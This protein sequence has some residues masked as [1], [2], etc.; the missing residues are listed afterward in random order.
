MFKSLIG[1][2]QF[3]KKILVLMLPIMIQNGITN[4]VNLLDN[5]MV[6]SLGTN[7]MTGVAISN[8]LIFVF[9]LCIFGAVSGASIFGAQF[10]GKG[11]DDGLRHTLRYK[12]IFCVFLTVA[13]I[14]VFFNFGNSLIG[15]YLKGEGTVTDIL[16]TSKY[17]QGYLNIILIGLIPYAVSQA[18]SGTLRETGKATPPMVAGLVAVVVNLVFNYILIFGKFGAPKLGIYGAAIATVL[19]RFV[20]LAIIVLYTHLNS[21]K[22]SFAKSLFRSFKIPKKLI[23]DITLKGMPLLINETLF[24]LGIAAI[25]RCYSLKGLEVVAANNINQTF[26]NFFAVVFSAAGAAITIILGQMLGANKT[27][28]AKDSAFKLIAFSVFVSTI[29]A[30]VFFVAAQFIPIFYN[31][32][33]EV[34]HLA[35]NLM[36]ICALFIPFDAY[37]HAAYFTIRS[38]GKTIITILFDSCFIWFVS[39]LTALLLCKYSSLS[40]LAIYAI[41]QSLNIIKCVIGYVLVKS[42]IWI[43]NIVDN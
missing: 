1:T 18:Y 5:I 2:K 6:G 40:I 31:T 8:Q 41:C 16:A 14:F 12:L 32:T 38:G 23:I 20:E 34:K 17:A 4:L 43:K 9:N 19:S 22:L 35:T 30:A 42:G 26:F 27:K 28:E 3:Y 36:R 39:F 21:N 11:D 7:Q 33:D 25:N 24:G 15:L 13:A 29:S 10:F 37:F